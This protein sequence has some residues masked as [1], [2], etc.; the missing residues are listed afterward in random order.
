MPKEQS[1]H[2]CGLFVDW[3][4][5]G[6]LN[7]LMQQEAS[8]HILQIITHLQ[9]AKN[10]SCCMLSNL[11]ADIF[12][13]QMC[14]TPRCVIP[15]IHK[16]Q[17]TLIES[18]QMAITSRWATPF[19]LRWRRLLQSP[20]AKMKTVKSAEYDGILSTNGHNIWLGMDGHGISSRRWI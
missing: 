14:E 20:S 11:T 9:R 1:Q 6:S 10:S 3:V 17:Q 15:R 16:K 2:P 13:M 12:L 18:A 8:V 4:E 19:H 7:E 5:V